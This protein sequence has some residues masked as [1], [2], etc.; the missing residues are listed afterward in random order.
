M[1]GDPLREGLD[2]GKGVDVVYDP[3]GGDL[4]RT[5]LRCVNPEARILA[6]GF[7]SGDVPQIPA[8]HLLVKNVDVLG[9]NFGGYLRFN[10]GA[11][12]ESFAEL[13]DWYQ[14]GRIKPHISH[15]FALSQAAE[16]LET[17]RARNSTGKIIVEIG[18]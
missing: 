1:D 14:A 13:I 3:V 2:V 8:N 18:S 4:F 12:A 5:A 6:I 7:A 15:R 10:P 16:A 17:L 9:L 11:L